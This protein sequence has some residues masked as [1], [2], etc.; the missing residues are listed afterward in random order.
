[1]GVKVVGLGGCGRN[2]LNALIDLGFDSSCAL[3]IDTDI[4]AKSASKAPFLQIGSAVCCGRG[5]VESSVG[6]AA[7]KES[8][9]DIVK[10]LSGAEVLIFV[11][12]LGG[13]TGAGALPFIATR[14]S[15][16]TTVIAVMPPKI[17]STRR[18]ER[19]KAALANLR[20]TIGDESLHFV[21]MADGTPATI[22]DRTDVTVAERIAALIAEAT[23]I[24]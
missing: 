9:D 17:E 18:K 6:L 7:A 23:V 11:A 24:S 13:G 1:M 14:V 21:E 15:A 2:S 5:A 4:N 12:G 19:A 20:A 22:F 8:E 10:E 16:K 3:N